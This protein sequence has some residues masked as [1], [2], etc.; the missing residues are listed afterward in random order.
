MRVGL[1]PGQGLEPAIVASALDP[2]DPVLL[3]AT[4]TLG[5][6]VRRRVEQVTRRS[7]PVLST[8]VAQPAIFVAGIVSFRRALER[9]ENF[10][11]LIGHSLGE[12]TAL[13][14]G[15]AISFTKGL[16][17]VAVRG[18]AMQKAGGSAPGGMAAVMNLSLPDVEY[19]CDETGSTIANDN[20]PEQIVLSGPEGALSRAAQIVRAMGGRSVLLPVDGPY[21]SAAMESAAG[22]VAR[23]LEQTEVRCPKIPVTSNVSAAPY[24]AP[25]EIRKLLALQMTNRVRFRESVSR[26]LENDEPEFVDLGPGRIVGRLAEATA[27]HARSSAARA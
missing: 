26:L 27:R 4:K 1:F 10:D 17:L 12:Y 13:V 8:S 9:G 7:R 19:V 23:A 15:G 5:Y 11:H 22:E 24:R 16:K 3:K 14:A 2:E 6:D 20:S 18:E 25:G 21:H